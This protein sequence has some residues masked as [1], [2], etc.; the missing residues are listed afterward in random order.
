MVDNYPC[1]SGVHPLY[2]IFLRFHSQ[3]KEMRSKRQILYLL[4]CIFF[5]FFGIVPFGKAQESAIY[6][7]PA[8]AFQKYHELFQHEKFVAARVGFEKLLNQ[9][10]TPELLKSEAAYYVAL[11][12]FELQNKDAETNLLAYIRNYPESPKTPY[13]SFKLGQYYFKQKRNKEAVEWFEKTD[14]SYL[15]NEEAA[16]YYFKIAYAYF[17][18]GNFEKASVNFYQLKDIDTKYTPAC[19]YYFAHIEYEKKNYETAL[20]SFLRLKNNATFS[21]IVPTYIVQ[22]FYLQQ[23]Y[24]SLIAYAA[25][26]VEKDNNKSNLEFIKLLGEAYYN[27]NVFSKAIKY[28][29][30]Y[31]A[32]NAAL[33][34]IEM[35]KLAYSYYKAAEWEK[36]IAYFEKIVNDKD[37][38]SQ[39]SYHHLADCFIKLNKKENARNAFSIAAG[40]DFDKKIQ[41]DALF[42]FARL[43]YELSYSSIALNAFQAYIKNYP[44]SARLTEANELLI[45]ILLSTKNYRDALIAI[46]GLKVK[47]EKIKSAY[48]RV[49]YNRGIDYYNDRDL[50]T[51]IE[52][53]NK[54]MTY[55]ISPVFAARAKFWTAESFYQLNNFAEAG[56]NYREFLFNPASVKLPFYEL[57]NYNLGYCYFKLP[58]Y[59]NSLEWFRK[60]IQF[61]KETDIIRYTDALIRIA[62][63][64]FMKRDFPSALDNYSQAIITK[65]IGTDYAMYQKGIILGIQNRLEDKMQMMQG[66][67]NEYKKSIYFDDAMYEIANSWLLLGQNEKALLNFEKIIKDFPSSSYVKKSLLKIGLIY[68]NNKQDDKAFDSYDQVIR[69]YS[70]TPEAREALTGIKNIYV[71]ASEADKFIKYAAEHPVANISSEEQD[72]LIYT[73]AELRY[74]KGE[75]ENAAID[76]TNYIGKFKNGYFVLNARY[77]RAEC[78]YNNQKFDAALD[79]YNFVLS[80]PKNTFT[81]KALLRASGIYYMQQKFDLALKNYKALEEEA[82]Y[83]DNLIEAA[84]G[85][86]R[87]AFHL[88]LFDISS[89]MSRRLIHS[90]KVKTEIVFEARLLLGKCLLASDSLDLALEQFELV[91]KFQGAIGAEA[92]YNSAFVQYKKANYVESKKIILEL[93]KLIPAY[94]FWIAKGFILLADDYWKMKDFFQAKATLQSIIENYEKAPEDPEDLIESAKIKLK[95]IQEEE[96]TSEQEVNNN[97]EKTSGEE[98]NESIE[99]KDK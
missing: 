1:K 46:E 21:A 49:C 71:N 75:Y 4:S 44:S 74:M 93:I 69:D 17:Q 29:S 40:M 94:D 56:K 82:E 39:N 60:Y 10:N 20:Q 23:K 57:A 70:A 47:S 24:D 12:S 48:Q 3:F 42:N 18:M 8:S 30:I 78:E 5:L 26:L 76:F 28:L 37:S 81:E 51:A 50:K 84:I 9:S 36:S 88:N 97:P 14:L 2:L 58:D 67:L 52:T 99:I 96:K 85:Q 77:Y 98:N 13:L 19:N 63:A 61:K 7:S 95:S 38:I 66:I 27:K 65:A 83:N 90:D 80:I 62:D 89:K 41:E 34:K 87:S 11:C 53:F 92:K 15:S 91:G 43:S 6:N 79:D 86:M 25:P 72:S 22:I 54:S 35:Y 73:S 68:Y 33:S 45:D 16:E 55:P 31:E 59:D 64:Y 32:K